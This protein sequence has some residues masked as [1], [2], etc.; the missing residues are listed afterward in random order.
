MTEED[1]RLMAAR[2]VDG[3]DY[4][5]K[6]AGLTMACVIVIGELEPGRPLR[7]TTFRCAANLPMGQVAEVLELGIEAAALETKPARGSA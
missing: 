3:I 1:L 6:S 4:A 7:N 5:N 2:M